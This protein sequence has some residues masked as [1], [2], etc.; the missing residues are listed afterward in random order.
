MISGKQI[1]QKSKLLKKRL[2]LTFSIVLM[3]MLFSNCL[4]SD[5][6]VTQNTDVISILFVGSSHVF[7]G[8]LP[9][10][11]QAITGIYGIDII[12]TDI[13]R[14]GNRG[15]TLGELKENAITEMQNRRFDYVVLQDQTRR[16]LNNLE[17][18]L[19]EIRDLSNE[20]RKSGTCTI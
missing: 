10:Q 9:R 3:T 6:H 19:N 12:F 13:S 1:K 2:H 11:L 14:H 17:G 20:A 5:T 15:G 4:N 16:S 18:L 8:N 7:V